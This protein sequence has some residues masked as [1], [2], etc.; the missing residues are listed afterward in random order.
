MLGALAIAEF[1]LGYRSRSRETLEL[2][3]GLIN[4]VRPKEDLEASLWGYR[5][6]LLGSSAMRVSA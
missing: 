5:K 6:E 4:D 1:R 3:T 2:Y